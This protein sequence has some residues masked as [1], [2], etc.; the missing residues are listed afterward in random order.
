MGGGVGV[1]V[2]VRRQEALMVK[3]HK[4]NASVSL[5]LYSRL[6]SNSLGFHSVGFLTGQAVVKRREGVGE[7]G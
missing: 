4:A 7:W 5:A 1:C 2:D 6:E 3:G